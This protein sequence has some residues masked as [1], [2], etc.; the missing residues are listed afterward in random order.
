[1][2]GIETVIAITIDVAVLDLQVLSRAAK[3]AT[4]AR[5]DLKWFGGTFLK[6]MIL[7]CKAF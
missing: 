5:A 7:K 2:V 1:M 6:V 4:V 3:G